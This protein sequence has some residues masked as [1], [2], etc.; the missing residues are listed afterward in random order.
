[1]QRAT[2]EHLNP[3][4]TGLIKTCTTKLVGT[5]IKFADSEVSRLQAELSNNPAV[6]LR[7]DALTLC[8][9]L[10][11]DCLDTSKCIFVTFESLQ[12][13][14]VMLLC[15]WFKGDWEWLIVSCDST[16]Q[17]SELS[18]TCLKVSEITK[19]NHSTKRVIILTE[20]S[21]QRIG[22]FV[23]IEHEFKFEQLSKE[24]Q[25]MVLDKTIDF[26]DCEVKMRSV[27]QQHGDVQHVLG[28]ELVTDV[29]TEGTT[30]NIG[31]R[32]HV[33]TENYVHRTLYLNIYL[34]L[35]VLRNPESCPDIF[36]VSGMTN[37]ELL[38]IVPTGEC[39][40]EE[41]E[42]ETRYTVK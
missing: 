42:D 21:V 41:F 33:N 32:L 2:T 11:L 15:A 13:N 28:P 30:V 19:S 25:E 20:C 23:P 8:S 34:E 39:V 16:V 4:V 3:F 38:N 14:K 36:V 35:G 37:Q 29:I 24:S 10:L 40:G 27:L 7:S 1:L 9:I 18:D 26:Q 31:G 17:P 6:H 12:N 5:G 22:N